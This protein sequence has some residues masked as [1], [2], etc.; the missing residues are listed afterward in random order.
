MHPNDKVYALDR[1]VKLAE[2][3]GEDRAVVEDLRALHA[4]AIR[5]QRGE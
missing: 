1:A 4:A 3:H 5:E 2:Q